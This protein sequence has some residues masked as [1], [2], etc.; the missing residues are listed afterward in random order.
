MRNVLIVIATCLLI[1]GAMADEFKSPDILVNSKL[2]YNWS[3]I[4]INRFRV[5][6]KNYRIDDPFKAQFTEPLVI[7]EDKVKN[8]LSAESLSMVNDFSNVIG[9]EIADSKTKVEMAGFAY[10]IKDFTTD[11]KSSAEM[12]DGLI[13]AS[14]V[15]A[16]ELALSAEKVTFSINI[17]VRGTNKST[18]ILKVD[19]IRPKISAREHELIKF[20]TK[21]K[22]QDQKDSYKF[23]ILKADFNNM[24]QNLLINPQHVDFS[25]EG[26]V[27]PNVSIKIGSKT[28]TFS[29]QK[30]E[31]FMRTRHEALKGIILAQLA[32]TLTDGTAHA[33]F[34]VLDKVTLP[35][36]HWFESE[37]IKSQVSISQFAS[38]L[39]ENHLEVKMPS[40]FCTM[41]KFKL[42][43]EKCLGSKDTL[44]SDSRI[45]AKLHEKS[46]TNMKDLMDVGDAN[47]V[48]S[49][50]EDYLNKLLVTTYD[51]GLWKD[52]LVQAGVELGP[53]KVTL[54]MDKKGDSGTLYMDVAYRPNTM[55]RVVLGTNLI[56]FPL[57]LDVSLRIEE[58]DEEPVVIVRLNEVDLSDDLL[59]NGRPQLGY[60]SNIGAIP[61]LR[62]KVLKTI[63]EKVSNLKAR[64]IVSLKYP[65]LKGL[66][67]ENV[68]FLSDGNGRMNAMM[69]LEDLLQ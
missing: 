1:T 62:G 34:K 52:A 9:L 5:L 3:G 35:K 19:V 31:N 58:Q 33:A 44:T 40:D 50:S 21:I 18:P 66:G 32:S 37:I 64:D 55:E 43:K 41:K 48:A 57:V 36:E 38:T 42:L 67:L 53:G 49:V 15:S 11:L 17:P 26:L 68:D 22:I 6:L 24:A 61:R 65:E 23:N 20:F 7:T 69:R 54:R 59:L 39:G 63:R 25:Y 8:Y 46:L 51:A 30:I 12:K 47:L 60:V 10:E 27:I 13:L 45:D 4:L 16:S 29:S 56:Q 2:D 14:D 28:I